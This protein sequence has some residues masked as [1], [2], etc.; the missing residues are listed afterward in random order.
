MV[1]QTCRRSSREERTE[2]F[3]LTHHCLEKQQAA[4]TDKKPQL[5]IERVLSFKVCGMGRDTPRTEVRERGKQ[6]WQLFPQKN[7]LC[8]F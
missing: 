3:F 8:L 1:R 7:M 6:F 4:C 2:L 5:E